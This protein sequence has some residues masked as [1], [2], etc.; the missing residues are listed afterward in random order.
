MKLLLDIPNKSSS[1]QFSKSRS[2]EANTAESAAVCKHKKGLIEKLSMCLDQ[3]LLETLLCWTTVACTVKTQ[4]TSRHIA[5]INSPHKW[6]S[7]LG[8][9]Q[10][11]PLPTIFQVE[12]AGYW[13]KFST[14]NNRTSDWPHWLRNCLCTRTMEQRCVGGLPEN[15]YALL[16]GFQN[17]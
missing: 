10:K 15:L 3:S 5:I 7:L 6:I 1:L 17:A 14:S 16:W 4:F 9:Y 12:W 8:D 2:C 11:L 13:V